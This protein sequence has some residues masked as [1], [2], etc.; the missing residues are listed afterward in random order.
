MY[1]PEIVYK[2]PKFLDSL[3][4]YFS[5]GPGDAKATGSV[6]DW[7]V[8]PSN[9]VLGNTLEIRGNATPEQ[10]LNI[11]V[12]FERNVNVSDGKYVYELDDVEIPEGSNSFVIKAEGV[13]DLN[14]T[15]KMFVPLTRTFQADG[16]VAKFSDSN[17]PSGSYDIRIDGNAKEGVSTVRLTIT[18][19]NMILVDSD[20]EFR[21]TYSTHFLPPGNFI[22]DVSGS[23]KEITLSPA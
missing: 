1:V 15:V 8:S 17:V 4:R 16:G 5:K 18:A 11:S 2:I 10:N 9:P 23:S 20:G 19:A 6:K 7:S 12:S 3:R 22:V 21:Y 13:E 14:F